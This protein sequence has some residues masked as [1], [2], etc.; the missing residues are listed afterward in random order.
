MFPGGN[1]SKVDA[2]LES[3]PTKDRKE[4]KKL[5]L[6]RRNGTW[7]VSAT[8]I[9]K[10]LAAKGFDVSDVNSSNIKDWRRRQSELQ[11]VAS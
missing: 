10:Y 4:I 6:G 1:L 3:I 5:I 8:R 11:A 2:F 7:A 9:V